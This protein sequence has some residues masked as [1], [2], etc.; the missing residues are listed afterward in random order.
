MKKAMMLIF[1]LLYQELQLGEVI[2][3]GKNS[4]YKIKYIET[5]EAERLAA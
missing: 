3:K 2:A 4:L 5:F 1:V